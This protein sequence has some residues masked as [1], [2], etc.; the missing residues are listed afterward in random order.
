[1]GVK[2][3]L[4]PPST[5]PFQFPEHRQRSSNSAAGG[6]WLSGG[7]GQPVLDELRTDGGGNAV[8]ATAGLRG[9]HLRQRRWKFGLCR[10]Y[11]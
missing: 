4:N 5:H 10:V 1:M 3:P 9:D 6:R 7:R 11:L 8:A 2:Q